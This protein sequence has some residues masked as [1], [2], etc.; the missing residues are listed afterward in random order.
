MLTVYNLLTA[1]AKALFVC[2]LED[3]GKLWDKDR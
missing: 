3:I 1:G 2:V